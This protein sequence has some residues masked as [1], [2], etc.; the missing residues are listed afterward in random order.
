VP[1]RLDILQ[2]S[3]LQLWCRAWLSAKR[4]KCLSQNLECLLAPG[5]IAIHAGQSPPRR[6]RIHMGR[7]K[8]KIE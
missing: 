4:I 1:N 6:D 3:L 7:S 2:D 5:K 8:G